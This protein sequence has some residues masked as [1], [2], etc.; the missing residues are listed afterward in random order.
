MNIQAPLSGSP[1]DCYPK[2]HLQLVLLYWQRVSVIDTALVIGYHLK[3]QRL[4]QYQ[5]F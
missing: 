3:M 1:L 5:L 2:F 4:P